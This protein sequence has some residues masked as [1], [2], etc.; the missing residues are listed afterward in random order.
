MESF[1]SLKDLI[2]CCIAER[3]FIKGQDFEFNCRFKMC[4]CAGVASSL[5][6]A[7]IFKC[8]QTPTCVHLTPDLTIYK[9]V[10]RLLPTAHS[11]QWAFRPQILLRLQGCTWRHRN[12]K[13][14]IISPKQFTNLQLPRL[15]CDGLT[16]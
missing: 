12:K 6:T 11:G 4:R 5:L 10:S 9:T 2:S 14:L 3:V 16:H 15:L 1:V 13:K 8:S 7:L